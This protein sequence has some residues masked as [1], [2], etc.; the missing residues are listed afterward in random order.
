MGCTRFFLFAY[1]SR[2]SH[3]LN[4]GRSRGFCSSNQGWRFI[5]CLAQVTILESSGRVG[6]RVETHR[7]E[8]EGWYADLGA[9]RIPSSHR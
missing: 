8:E 4:D 7:N 5:D 1:Y 6:G 9:M 3:K 2:E